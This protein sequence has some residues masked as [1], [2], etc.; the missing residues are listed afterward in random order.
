MMQRI[1]RLAATVCGLL[2]ALVAVDVSVAYADDGDPVISTTCGA[3]TVT[4]CGT[5]PI[6]TCDW[7]V[8]I[9]FGADRVFH[10]KLGKTN[11]VVTG[12]VP[13][14]K[15]LKENSSLSGACNFLNP[16]LGMPLGSGCSDDEEM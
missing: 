11:C 3:G 5:K 14:Y 16:L 12:H 2:L 10:L 8:D 7:V 9:G 1:P 13:I 6:V 4:A 15:D